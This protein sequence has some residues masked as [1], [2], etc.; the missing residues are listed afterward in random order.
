MDPT[1][2]TLRLASRLFGVP[3]TFAVYDT[4]AEVLIELHNVHGESLG[5]VTKGTSYVAAVTEM[6]AKLVRA[7][8]E[9]IRVIRATKCATKAD[10]ALRVLGL[11]GL[12]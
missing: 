3:A 9:G 10:E 4:D 1:L 7:Y 2:E 12:R 8:H 11:P 6:R 5:L